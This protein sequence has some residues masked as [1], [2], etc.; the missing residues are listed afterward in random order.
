MA[1]LECKAPVLAVADVKDIRKTIDTLGKANRN[2]KTFSLPKSINQ[3]QKDVERGKAPKEIDRFDKGKGE[4]EKPHVH[5][6]DGTALNKD[7]TLKHGE[8]LNISNKT[9]KYLEK[10]DWNIYKKE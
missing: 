6:V 5:F 3:L 10:N 7:G 9:K 2:K 1:H 8:K 4:N